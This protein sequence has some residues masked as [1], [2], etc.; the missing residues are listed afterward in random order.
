MASVSNA[1]IIGGGI[2]GL[3]AA[4]ALSRAG[5]QCHVIERST[6]RLGAGLGLTGRVGEALVEL[7]VYDELHESG[8]VFGEDTT[9]LSQ[10]DVAGNII[11]PGNVRPPAWP[12]AVQP[13][14]V[15]RP[16]LLDVLDKTAQ[17]LGATIR[18][19][20]TATSIENGADAARVVFSDGTEGDYDLVVGA[21]GINSGTRGAIFPDAPKPAYAG[22]MSVRF[23]SHGDAIDGEGWYNGPAGRFGFYHLPGQQITYMP[24]ELNSDAP[25]R[26]SQDEAYVLVR[27]LLDSFTAPAAKELRGRLQPDSLLVVRPFESILVPSPWY[28]GRVVLIG[29]AAHA[30]TAH[31]GQGAAMA[32]EDAVVLGQSVA[33]ASTLADALDAYVERRFERVRTVVDS[34]I[35]LC[36][37]QQEHAPLEENMA[38]LTTAL[39]T[40]AQPY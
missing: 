36:R 6:E 38:V 2:A 22:Q 8:R 4:V 12:G 31:M 16:T 25:L 34:S 15:Y 13:I 30:T 28:R 20:I 7:G 33:A 17:E 19:E 37:L 26:L 35:A 3:S 39:Q 24:I 29:D 14:A 11:D 9:A 40:I 21:D 32:I 10:R 27:D 1:L 5:V 23:M 18:T